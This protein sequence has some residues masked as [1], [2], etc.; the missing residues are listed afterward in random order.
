MG[1]YGSGPQKCGPW[2]QTVEDCMTLSAGK[3]TG[4]KTLAGSAEAVGTITWSRR[5]TGE[6]IL[7]VHFHADVWEPNEASVRLRYTTPRSG[8]DVDYEIELTSTPMPSG[9][10]RWWFI[11][12]LLVDGWECRRRV[13]KLYLPRGAKYF[14]CRHCHDL[15]YQSCRNSHRFDELNVMLGSRFGVSPKAI[16]KILTGKW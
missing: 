13:G 6:D 3:L 5:F 11:C 16:E 7:A 15:T 8:E 2:R 12:P 1:G 9:G 10:V 4:V 14:G